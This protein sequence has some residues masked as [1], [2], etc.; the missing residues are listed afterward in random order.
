MDKEYSVS[1]ISNALK[2][3]IETAFGSVR[4]R[5][6]ISELKQPSSG[7]IY[8]SLKEGEQILSTI[9]WK[10]QADKLQTKLEA[11]AEV[12]CL[13]KISTYAPQS[14]YNLIIEDVKLA[15]IGAILKMLEERKKRLAAEGLFD[16]SKKKLLPYIPS[17]IGIITSPGGAV[18]RDIMHRLSERFPRKVI[19]WS[20]PVQGEGAALQIAG[21]VRGFNALEKETVVNGQTLVKPDLLIVARGGGSVEDLMPFNEEI[22]VRAVAES[23][24]PVISAIGHE[25]DVTLID[26]AADYRAPT[27]TGAAEKAVPVRKELLDKLDS[28]SDRLDKAFHRYTAIRFEKLDFLMRAIGTPESIIEPL[29]HRLDDRSERLS[30]SFDSVMLRKTGA[31]EKVC[32]RLKHPIDII[33]MSKQKQKHISQNLEKAMKNFMIQ[34]VSGFDSLSRTL[35]ILSPKSVL[36]RGYTLVKNKEGV[37]ITSSAYLKAGNNIAIEF[38]DGTKDAVIR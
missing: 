18:I 32:G 16:V 24:I 34:N 8:F 37:L 31:L 17:C 15:G 35:Q 4:V 3:N 21:A 13:G 2:T 7:H 30:I 20:V 14:K 19:L 25:T 27:P 10:W 28:F 6:E 23:A 38:S 36:Q 12:V 29:A 1:E 26:Y 11:G 9:C 33:N 5:G 22:V